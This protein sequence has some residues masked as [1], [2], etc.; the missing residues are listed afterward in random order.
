MKKIMYSM[1]AFMMA[2]FTFTSCEDV[3]APYG[4]PTG[5]TE[6]GGT[7]LP[8]GTFLDADFTNSLGKFKS[9]SAEGDGSV[10]WKIN[11]SSACITGY[12]KWNGADTKSNK[13][14]VTYL[15][16]PEVD[17]TN[18][19]EAHVE[20][21]QALKYEKADINTN[22]SLLITDNFTGDVKTTTWKQLPYNTDGLNDASTKEFVFVTSAANI[23]AEFMGKKVVIAL[24]H[25]CSD[26]QSSTWE[27]KNLKVLTGKADVVVPDT[28]VTP[29]TGQAKGT[30]TKADPFNS[31]AANKAASAL[32][33][34]AESEQEYYIKG[35][36]C[37]IAQ[38]YQ[39]DQYGNASF[40]ISDDGTETDKFYCYHLL[41]LNNEKYTEGKTNIAVGD[42]VVVCAKIMN[43]MGNTPETVG[44]KGYLVE[45]KSN[46]GTTPD[47]PEE[48]GSL[49]GDLVYVVANC[50]LDNLT[51]LTTLKLSDDLT[52]TFD[53]GGNKNAPKY[54]TT[55]MSFRMYP[56]N[57]VKFTST[58]K[59]ASVTIKCD[60]YNGTIY[61]ASGDMTASVG[62]FSVVGETDNVTITDINSTE[63]TLTD[64][65]T[66]TGAPSQF[67]IKEIAVTY[68]K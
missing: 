44:N 54:Y 25:T 61:N 26:T 51:A 21:N 17:L 23:P 6:G 10:R 11:Y 30:G 66:T 63:F 38:A 68:A 2:A 45:L 18:A 16:S 47:T 40:Y 60:I 4:L 67:R 1:L 33:A 58:K 65:S 20:L 8:E 35:K 5:G 28:P 52:L 34:G 27:V 9:M 3:P 15:V 57:T 39:A 43:Y 31:V 14:G 48:S 59:I 19:T 42:E 49:K 62:K 41:Y 13:A 37:K 46:G 50:G 24:R 36:V 32:A 7:T 22:N 12:D 56:K 53:G 64:S 29:E 55:G